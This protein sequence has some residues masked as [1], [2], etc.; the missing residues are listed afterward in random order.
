MTQPGEAS[1]KE[2]RIEPVSLSQ[3]VA[4][5]L[6]REILAGD[7]EPGAPIVVRDLVGRLGVSHIPIREALRELEAES[8][9]VSRP[10]Q[11]VIVSGVDLDELHDLY[12]LRRLLE[13]DAVRRAFPAYT[14]EFLDGARKIF[15]EL[16]GLAPSQGDS[17]WWGVHKRYHWTFLQ[18]GLTPW[19][20]K[21]LQL[22]WQT[23]ERYQRL[24]I[25]VFGS[26]EEANVEHDRV[27][28]VASSGNLEAFIDAWLHHLD[29]T[30]KS[31]VSG[32]LARHGRKEDSPTG[33][34]SVRQ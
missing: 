10:G 11:S 21:L 7:L 13:V 8:L 22:I 2:D 25:L 17:R 32:Y 19:S 9:V 1:T 3:Q 5:R 30:E 18:P 4:T 34:G 28:A 33:T 15:D 26:V 6:R 20:T 31:I 14:S 23:S 16:L 24:Y 12:R 29:R 27:L